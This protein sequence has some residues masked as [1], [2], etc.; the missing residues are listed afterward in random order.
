M[1]QAMLAPHLKHNANASS[2]E[3]AM[4]F[5]IFGGAFSIST[6]LAGYVS[7]S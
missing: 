7:V 6:P 5:F 3:V 1:A 4:A 2:M